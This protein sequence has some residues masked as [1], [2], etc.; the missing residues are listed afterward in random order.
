MPPYEGV[1]LRKVTLAV[2][3]AALEVE[4]RVAICGSGVGASVCA[5]KVQGIRAAVIHDHFSAKQGV[6]DDHLNILCMGDRKST[7]LNSVTIIS[8]MP[9]SA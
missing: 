2:A 8:R 6:V 4:R 7:R 1:F 5:N 9:S 3:V